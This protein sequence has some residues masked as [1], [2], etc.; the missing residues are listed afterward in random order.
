MFC[1]LASETEMLQD[2][3]SNA[4]QVVSLTGVYLANV[5]AVGSGYDCFSRD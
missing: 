5:V 1:I 4:K 3:K 2:S